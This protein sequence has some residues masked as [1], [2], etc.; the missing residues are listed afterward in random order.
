[1]YCPLQVSRAGYLTLAGVCGIEH[2]G[3]LTKAREGW[4][5]WYLLEA[6]RRSLPAFIELNPYLDTSEDHLFSTFEIDS[7]LYNIAIIDGKRLRFGAW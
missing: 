3:L 5:S 7:Q 6:A 4:I 2:C 1:M